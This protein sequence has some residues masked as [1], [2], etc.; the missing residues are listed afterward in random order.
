MSVECADISVYRILSG[1]KGKL[2]EMSDRL[3]ANP[4]LLADG[5]LYCCNSFK[6]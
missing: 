4:K 5:R 2:I 6:A 3:I 1:V